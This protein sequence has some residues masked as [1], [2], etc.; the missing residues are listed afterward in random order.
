[1]IFYRHG[2]QNAFDGASKQA[3]DN[4]FGTSNEDECMIKILEHGTLQETEV[5][6]VISSLMEIY[7]GPNKYVLDE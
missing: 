5:R 2:A 1:M 6:I 4:E 3:L 7:D